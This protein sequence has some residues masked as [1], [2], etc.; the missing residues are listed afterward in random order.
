MAAICE[1]VQQKVF[2]FFRVLFMVAGHTKFAP[3][4][5]FSIV[6]LAYYAF[7]VF[8]EK[9]LVDAVGRHA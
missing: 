3:D 9:Q 4:Q 2:H 7:Y 1:V 5:L 6:A 8:N